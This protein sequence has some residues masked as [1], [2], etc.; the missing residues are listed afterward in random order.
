MGVTFFERFILPVKRMYKH[1]NTTNVKKVAVI[2]P[3]IT[4]VAKGFC[5]SAPAPPENAIGR[6]PKAATL[7]VIKTGR[8]RILVPSITL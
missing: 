2:K 7:A 5:T 1:G 6:K 4:T 8:K 3:P